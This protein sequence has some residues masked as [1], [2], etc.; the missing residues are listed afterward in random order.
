M[1]PLVVSSLQQKPKSSLKKKKNK[2]HLVTREIK[3][4]LECSSNSRKKAQWQRPEVT[5]RRN[6]GSWVSRDQD[7]GSW[8]AGSSSTGRALC[9]PGKPTTSFYLPPDNYN[10]YKSNERLGEREEFFQFEQK[11]I[12]RTKNIRK[13]LEFNLGRR[14]FHLRFRNRETKF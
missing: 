10:V 3:I 9:L 5:L 14:S 12:K 4:K 7:Y 11:F 6:E 2:E 8:L 1:L 13:S